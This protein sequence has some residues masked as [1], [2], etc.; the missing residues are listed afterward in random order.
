MACD[1]KLLMSILTTISRLIYQW[2]TLF[3]GNTE[4]FQTLCGIFCN[5]DPS[6]PVPP[7]PAILPSRTSSPDSFDSRSPAE[8]KA[9][10]DWALPSSFKT[11]ST[12]FPVRPPDK[13]TGFKNFP[14]NS[15]SCAPCYL[16]G[17]FLP[18]K[19]FP[20][21]LQLTC[22]TERGFAA[23]RVTQSK[24]T[25]LSLFSSPLHELKQE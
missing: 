4:V 11:S 24:P 14:N 18:C 12:Q 16:A 1:D 9:V 25:E 15:P 20:P 19:T 23:N 21:G 10:R 8:N 17:K 2:Y 6:F 3:W 7:L 22:L 13:H 5:Y